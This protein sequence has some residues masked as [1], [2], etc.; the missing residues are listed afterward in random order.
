MSVA[1][2]SEQPTAEHKGLG[3]RLQGIKCSGIKKIR[4]AISTHVRSIINLIIRQKTV[5]VRKMMKSL[6]N[7]G[8]LNTLELN[9]L[10]LILGFFISI[11]LGSST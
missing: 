7:L 4:S 10:Q 3:N 9:I 2:F 5:T 8:L 11:K 1:T 6:N